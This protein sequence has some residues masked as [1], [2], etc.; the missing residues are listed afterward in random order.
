MQETNGGCELPCWWGITPGET[1]V[2]TAKEILSPLVGFKGLRSDIGFHFADYSDIDVS[3]YAGDKGFITEIWTL[4]SIRDSDQST[5]YHPS[6]QRYFVSEL[7]TKLGMPSQVWLGFGPHSGDHDERPPESIP[8][9]YELYVI[10]GDSGLVVQYAGPAAQGNLNRAC[11][12]FEQLKD[13]RI[14][15]RQR[16]K[17][18]L[19]GPPW[20]PFT[21]ARPISEVTNLS[22]EAFYKLVKN[23]KGPVCI[24][25]PAT[26]R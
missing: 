7:L 18:P 25:S 3:L 16:S 9:F 14:F 13:M 26:H 19:I 4:S 6:W 10:Y 11:L 24:E 8:F 20:E 1:T 15:V 22:V 17:G 23:T 2:Q 21:D 5:R 12:S